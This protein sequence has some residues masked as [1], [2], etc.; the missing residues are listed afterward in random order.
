MSDP[1]AA[2]ALL[3]LK[4]LIS[5]EN[6]QNDAATLHAQM[7]SVSSQLSNR[8]VLPAM[9][10]ALIKRYLWAVGGSETSLRRRCRLETGVA[11]SEDEGGIEAYKLGDLVDAR[12]LLVGDLVRLTIH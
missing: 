2:T 1:T 9:Q 5:C 11:P 3:A 4:W 12:Y 6:M 8:Q 10:H 7:T